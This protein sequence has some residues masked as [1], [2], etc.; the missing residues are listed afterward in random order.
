[1]TWICKY[2]LLYILFSFFN[3]VA[4]NISSSQR[5]DIQTIQNF[6]KDYVNEYVGTY[7]FVMPFFFVVAFLHAGWTLHNCSHTELINTGNRRT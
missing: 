4:L 2:V 3:Q 6:V 7:N 1:M 5:T